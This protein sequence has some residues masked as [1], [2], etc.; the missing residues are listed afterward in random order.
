MGKQ[1]RWRRSFIAYEIDRP[2]QSP[3]YRGGCEIGALGQLI[4]KQVCNLD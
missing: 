3:E 1:S 2:L 4:K